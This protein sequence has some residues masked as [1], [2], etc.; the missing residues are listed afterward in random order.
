MIERLMA[1]FL[2]ASICLVGLGC[3]STAASS[4]QRRTVVVDRDSMA[5]L[6]RRIRLGR[7][8]QGYSAKLD[9]ISAQSGTRSLYWLTVVTTSPSDVAEAGGNWLFMKRLLIV[10][11]DR[12][13][14][15]DVL[16]EHRRGEWKTVLETQPPAPAGPDD[17]LLMR[18]SEERSFPI[19][20]EQL[21]ALAQASTVEIQ[22]VGATARDSEH[23]I[24]P[25]ELR[26]LA[27]W[28]NTNVHRC[29]D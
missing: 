14:A 7:S 17:V 26:R 20:K 10:T 19:T 3:P 12:S 9:V 2:L 16:P 1:S 28:I 5:G 15:L 27:S 22:I 23:S 18:T 25:K 4:A 21:F 13:F 24:K 29:V 6:S 8:K 11:D